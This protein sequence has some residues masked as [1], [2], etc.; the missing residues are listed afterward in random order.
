MLPG[1][2]I[3]LSV[4]IGAHDGEHAPR[5]LRISGIFRAALHVGGVV[6]DFE[7]VADTGE[8]EPAEVVLAVRIV[9]RETVRLTD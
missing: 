1:A 8:F 9:L 3:Y 4:F 2:E 6:V 5:L 7:E